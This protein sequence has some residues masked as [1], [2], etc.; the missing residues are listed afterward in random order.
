MRKP[1]RAAKGNGIHAP[2][3]IALN[4]V[5]LE[6]ALSSDL[7]HLRMDVREW[8]AAQRRI[9]VAAQHTISMGLLPRFIARLQE[10]L[11]R[12]SVPWGNFCRRPLPL[13]ATHKNILATARQGVT[14]SMC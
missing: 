3:S 12:C 1:N 8:E 6:Q 2:A 9:P 11:G 7:R 4:A 10:T 14:A 13:L 5:V